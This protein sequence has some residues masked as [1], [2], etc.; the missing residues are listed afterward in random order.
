MVFGMSKS[1]QKEENGFPDDSNTDE[2]I[3]ESCAF[4]M[5]VVLLIS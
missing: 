5:T 2:D 3:E 1:F 4:M